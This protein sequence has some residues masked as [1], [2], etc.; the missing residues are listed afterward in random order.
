M[1][2]TVLRLSINMYC[3]TQ[4]IYLFIIS[5]LIMLTVITCVPVKSHWL[6][7]KKDGYRRCTT[8]RIVTYFHMSAV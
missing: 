6:G 3:P 7:S 4:K 1:R 5:H 8:S 2:I